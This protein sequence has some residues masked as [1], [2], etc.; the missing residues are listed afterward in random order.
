VW[1]TPLTPGALLS[2]FPLRTEGPWEIRDSARIF[3][4]TLLLAAGK[5]KMDKKPDKSY[6]PTH[7]NLNT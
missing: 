3:Q 5:K 7:V 6:D 1:T 2:Q 4:P